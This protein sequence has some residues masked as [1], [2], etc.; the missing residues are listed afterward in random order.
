MKVEPDRHTLWM[1]ITNKVFLKY[2]LSGG[3]N[4]ISTYIIY[5]LLL[6]VTNYNV[7][8]SISYVSGIF[9]SY[10][11]NSV[12]VFKEQ[13]SIRKFIKYPIVY[14]VQYVVNLILINILIRYFGLSSSLVPIIVI[15]LTIPITFTLSKI[16]IKGK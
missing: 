3:I 13:I 4:T 11:L 15:I 5:L 7:S 9:L 10:Y 16:I 1:K 14:V 12:F 2:V 6:K 8:Y